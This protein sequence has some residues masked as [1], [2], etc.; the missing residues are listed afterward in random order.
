MNRNDF[1]RSL[2]MGFAGV[3]F[4]RN[5]VSAKVTGSRKINL[6]LVYIS[7]FQFYDGA[8]VENKLETLMPLQLNREPNNRYDTN[9]IEIYAGDAKLGYL[10]RQSNTPISNM[11]DQ[12]IDIKAAITELDKDNFPNRSV[13]VE[14]FYL[15]EK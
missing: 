10:P 1:F 13:K 7:G 3:V 8:E 12:G 6:A 9:A 4:F 15:S 11:M 5:K 14:V 2:I